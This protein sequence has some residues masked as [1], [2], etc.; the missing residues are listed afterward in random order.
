MAIWSGLLVI[1]LSLLP[2]IFLSVQ[3]C[4]HRVVLNAEPTDRRL[5]CHLQQIQPP[6]PLCLIATLLFTYRRLY[7]WLLHGYAGGDCVETSHFLTC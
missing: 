4:V 7:R 5:L 1:M 3:N 2:V 6:K